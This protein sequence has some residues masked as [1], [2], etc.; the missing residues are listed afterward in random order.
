MD[1]SRECRGR[2]FFRDLINQIKE[3]YEGDLIF[4]GDFNSVM[5]EGLDKS[6]V[7]TAHS[8]MPNNWKEWIKD[9]DVRDIWRDTHKTHKDY[10]FYS[11]KFD[12]FFRI[13]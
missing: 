13:D 1:I 6:A 11:G 2:E 5:D 7:S 4:M 3:H 8:R 10:T 9:S 12:S